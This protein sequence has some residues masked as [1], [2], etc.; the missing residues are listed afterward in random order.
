MKA[1]SVVKNNAQAIVAAMIERNLSVGEAAR[2]VGL[3]ADT[4]TRLIR[5]NQPIH[6]KTAAKLVATFGKCVVTVKT[7]AEA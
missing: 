5:V 3:H 2:A 6:C 4:M 1:S 7:A